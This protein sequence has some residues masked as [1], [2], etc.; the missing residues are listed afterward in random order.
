MT[1]DLSSGNG[2]SVSASTDSEPQDPLLIAG[3]SFSS[4]LMTGTGKYSSMAS[5]QA[6]I[7]ASG[8]SIVTVAVRRVQ[9]QAPGHSGLMEA[10]DWNRIWMLPNTAGCATAEEAVRVARLGRGAQNAVTAVNA[11]ITVLGR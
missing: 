11:A 2:K 8:C 3:R 6:C 9:G 7:E 5:M 10:I 1:L 4:R